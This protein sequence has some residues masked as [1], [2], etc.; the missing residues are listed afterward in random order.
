MS[1]VIWVLIFIAFLVATKEGH[2][3]TFMISIFLLPLGFIWGMLIRLF[4]EKEKDDKRFMA[5]LMIVAP[6]AWLPIIGAFAGMFILDGSDA[7]LCFSM[8]VGFACG[9]YGWLN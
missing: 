9:W 8:L 6:G 7:F 5:I 4:Y 3:D 1:K 2:A